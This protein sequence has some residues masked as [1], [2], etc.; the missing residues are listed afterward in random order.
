MAAAITDSFTKSYDFKSTTLSSSI[1]NSDTTIACAS[2]SG[3]PTDTAVFFV[4]DYHDANGAVTTGNVREICKGIVSGN[5]FITCT[6][7]LSNSTAQAHAAGAVVELNWTAEA[8]EALVDGILVEHRQDGTHGTI[9]TDTINEHTA[10]TGVTIDGVLLKDNKVATSSAVEFLAVA[11]GM[12]L[13]CVT[14]VTSSV[15]TGT[16]L[17]PDDNSIPQSGEGDQYMTVSITPKLATSLLVIE[18]VVYGSN[19]GAN[20]T[21]VALFQDST[22]NALAAVASYNATATARMTVPLMY[23]M[24]SGT[25]SSTTFKIR[26]GG[27]G[28]GTFT[29]NG[30]SGGVRYSTTAKSF[31]KVTEYKA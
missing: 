23:S 4:I 11:N 2:L 5:S 12:A 24:T 29:F 13:Q 7:G 18:A 8:L 19:S 15:A 26:A 25:T 31:M 10:A 6:R 9:T 16:L 14:S 3:V 27:S 30:V 22:A 1:N 28:A 20:D 17:I 21:T